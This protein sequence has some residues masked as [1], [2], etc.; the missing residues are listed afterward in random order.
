MPVAKAPSAP[1][2]GVCESQPTTTIPGETRPASMMT[3]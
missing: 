3:W 2:I 1:Y